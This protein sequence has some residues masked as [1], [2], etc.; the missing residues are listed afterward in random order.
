MKPAH[1]WVHYSLPSQTSAG[2][3]VKAVKYNLEH[4]PDKN[5]SADLVYYETTYTGKMLTHDENAGVSDLPP[6]WYRIMLLYNGN[7]YRALG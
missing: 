1:R 6:G 7:T 5:S 2:K 3:L 4:H